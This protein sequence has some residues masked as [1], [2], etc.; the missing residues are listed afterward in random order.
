MPELGGGALISEVPRV[1]Y[2]RI[3]DDFM[4]RWMPDLSP[5][6]VDLDYGIMDKTYSDVSNTDN[7]LSLLYRESIPGMI[8]F[9]FS[10]LP[11]D[12]IRKNTVLDD[13]KMLNRDDVTLNLRDSIGEGQF[14]HGTT[15]YFVEFQ[16]DSNFNLSLCRQIQRSENGFQSTQIIYI[17]NL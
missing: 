1:E 17:S 2:H 16:D 13:I 9:D 14:G 12:S 8:T 3:D 10:P 15:A 11:T 6:P 7:D 4:D 5:Q